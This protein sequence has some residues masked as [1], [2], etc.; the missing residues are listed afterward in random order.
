MLQEL[1]RL[2]RTL[3]DGS[4]HVK[5]QYSK[6][7]NLTQISVSRLNYKPVFLKNIW[8]N[9]SLFLFSVFSDIQNNYYNK[10]IQYTVWDSNPRP[11]EHESSPEPLDQG[12]FDQ[13]MRL[14]L[15]QNTPFNET[16]VLPKY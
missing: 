10:T 13:T 8:A 14:H 4:P 6:D 9:P 3:N 16:W 5:D 11:L 1:E 2:K 12:T 15:G 7:P